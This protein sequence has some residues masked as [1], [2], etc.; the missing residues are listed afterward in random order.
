MV[1]DKVQTF[2]QKSKYIPL[3]QNPLT[4][5]LISLAFMVFY[6]E[7]RFKKQAKVPYK[8]KLKLFVEL[9]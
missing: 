1:F 8:C 5:N 9:A 2:L 3:Q 7:G 4:Q 6:T